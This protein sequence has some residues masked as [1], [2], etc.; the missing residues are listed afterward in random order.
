MSNLEIFMLLAA[1]ICF[2]E[3]LRRATFWAGDNPELLLSRTP[4]LEWA[5]MNM[6]LLTS[7]VLIVVVAS[8]AFRGAP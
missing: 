2:V 6:L 7:I 3:M 4:L 8:R 1:G 5:K